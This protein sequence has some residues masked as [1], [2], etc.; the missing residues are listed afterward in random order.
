MRRLIDA[1]KL[2]IGI[3][4]WAVLIF[5]AGW[6]GYNLHSPEPYLPTFRDIQE[7]LVDRGYDIE[8]DGKIGRKTIEAWDRAICEDHAAKYF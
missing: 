7:E 5:G 4:L 3:I 1:L 6:I 2:L 8:V